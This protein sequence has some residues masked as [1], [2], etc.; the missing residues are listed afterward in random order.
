M[1][2]GSLFSKRP[3]VTGSNCRTSCLAGV[4]DFSMGSF[5]SVPR[6]RFLLLRDRRVLGLAVTSSVSLAVRWRR[7][8]PLQL[9]QVLQMEL[10]PREVELRQPVLRVEFQVP[11]SAA[12]YCSRTGDT[13]AA[14]FAAGG[15]CNKSAS[16]SAES[17]LM[18]VTLKRSPSR[19][20]TAAPKRI[21]V[22]SLT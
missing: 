16:S 9:R 11:V 18:I 12:S 14:L 21:C 4:T 5:S 15:A 6:D 17:E 7:E 13:A 3:R 22:W 8:V 2:V 10:F 20:S 1:I 19:A